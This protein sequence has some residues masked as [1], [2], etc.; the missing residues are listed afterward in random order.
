MPTRLY[1]PSGGAAPVS[2]TISATDWNAH[3]NVQRAPLN[4]VNGGSAMQTLTFTP[5][6]SDHLTAGSTHLVQFVSDA[7]PPQVIAAQ[8]IKLQCRASEAHANNN[9]F[10]AWKLYAVALDGASV[11]G[12]LVALRSDNTEAA[13]ALTNR[14]DSAT[15]TAFSATVPFR[16]VLEVGFTGTPTAT[17]GVQ[18]HNG[19]LSFGENGTDLPEDDAAT[20]ALSP[21]LQFAQN[22]NFKTGNS[23]IGFAFASVCAGGG[24]NDLMVSLN[25]GASQHY[26][27]TTDDIRAP[28]SEMS[29]EERITATLFLLKLHFAGKTRAEVLAELSPGIVMVI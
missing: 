21:W 20:G 17:S 27:Y 22:L 29:E 28:L 8:T 25:G 23:Y 14:G 6:A 4:F 13:T 2:P 10:L 16:L 12:T 18:G 3:I 26:V 19:A 5:D 9:L 15:S 1:L 11:L 7:L 24:H